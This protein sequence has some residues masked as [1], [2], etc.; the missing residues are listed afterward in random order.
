VASYYKM[1]ITNLLTGT[2]AL[3]NRAFLPPPYNVAYGS[4][5]SNQTQV[6]LGANTDTPITHNETYI[7]SQTAIDPANP[8]RIVVSVSGVY[9]FSFSIQL[10]KAGAGV[11]L[12]DFWIKKNGT[13]VPSSGCR[14]VVAGNN[15]ETF[16]YCEYL[17]Q[18]EA[19]QYIE[20]YI[21]SPDITMSAAAFVA[22]GTVPAVPSIITNIIQIS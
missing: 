10:D 9:K 6:V 11:S 22:A 2:P 5:G 19:G 8:S 13:N 21:L 3:I 16:P 18:M 15:G 4:F 7:A 14:A 12:C 20:V 1:S 17:I